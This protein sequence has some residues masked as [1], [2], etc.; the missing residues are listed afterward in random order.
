MVVVDAIFNPWNVEFYNKKFQH[1]HQLH[2]TD[3]CFTDNWWPSSQRTQLLISKVRSSKLLNIWLM[4]LG[5]DILW[6][7]CPCGNLKGQC[8]LDFICSKVSKQTSALMIGI[9][10][11]HPTT[12][13]VCTTIFLLVA[14]P[15]HC[16]PLHILENSRS[17]I[18]TKIQL[19]L[20]SIGFHA[21]CCVEF[22]Q[23][24]FSFLTYWCPDRI[25]AKSLL[26]FT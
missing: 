10:V 6:W 13:G 20:V 2:F 14:L 23:K 7:I 24:R 19:L 21:I 22:S 3:N 15:W 18:S 12:T 1:K 5:E 4:L 26:S 17:F 16:D 25:W 9:Y 11:Y 8:F